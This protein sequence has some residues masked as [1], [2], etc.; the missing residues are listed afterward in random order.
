MLCSKS[1]FSI[2]LI[3]Y[4]RDNLQVFLLY[5]LESLKPLSPLTAE[6]VQAKTPLRCKCV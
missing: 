5:V 2:G 4:S 1:T 3:L 6:D